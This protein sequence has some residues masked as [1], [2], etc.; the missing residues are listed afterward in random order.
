MV[1]SMPVNSSFKP[2]WWLP[3]PHLQT[4]WPYFIRRRTDIPLFGERLELPDGDFVD[5]CWTSEPPGSGS[6]PV[7]AVFHGLEGSIDSPYARPMLK[8]LRDAGW[9]GVFMHFRGCSGE[10]NRLARSYH[11][12]DTGDIRFLLETLSARFPDAPLC[13]IGYSL[14]GNALLKYLGESGKTAPLRCAVAISVPFLLA[15]GARRLNR[16]FSRIYQYHLISR[17]KQKILTKFKD[18]PAPLDIAHVTGLNTFYRFDND[19]T[20]PLHGFKSADDYYSRC[21][22]RRFLKSIRVPALILHSRDDPFMTIEAIPEKEEL[23][24]AVT[25]E[26]SDRGGHVGFVSGKVPGRAVY[27]LEQRVPEFI[28]RHL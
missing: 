15:N 2:A 24:E 27:W 5:L 13:A 14:G 7:V 21:S 4:L 26:L 6:A 3:G 20:A 1:Q 19:I 18:R 28:Q 17:L 8:Q 16:G 10:P 9:R 12:G 23:A 11:S 25:L 22:S